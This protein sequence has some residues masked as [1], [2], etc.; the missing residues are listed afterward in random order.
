MTF[1]D[2][3]LQDEA[4]LA[5]VQSISKNIEAYGRD[6]LD[7]TDD[8]N[9]QWGP[10][11]APP[12]L[13][14][15]SGQSLVF[16]VLNINDVALDG[17]NPKGALDTIVR[18]FDI[19]AFARAWREIGTGAPP[20]SLMQTNFL[21]L[22]ILE[23]YGM[24]NQE[25][26]DRVWQVSKIRPRYS[27]TTTWRSAADPNKLI[28]KEFRPYTVRDL[29]PSA[30][31]M[32][33]Y[34]TLTSIELEAIQLDEGVV[35]QWRPQTR[36]LIEVRL[37]SPL[38]L[39]VTSGLVGKSFAEILDHPIAGMIDA[40]VV[41]VDRLRASTRISLETRRPVKMVKLGRDAKDQGQYQKE[42]TRLSKARERLQEYVVQQL[43]PP[44]QKPN[45]SLVDGDVDK[46]GIS[47][48]EHADIE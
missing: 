7:L 10:D 16:P 35:L 15:A 11:G 36:S 37:N 41:K 26:A 27:E 29:P 46:L 5:S 34:S 13:S 38:P 31:W 23:I 22:S 1:K 40:R 20:I 42:R 19:L 9:L 44:T 21:T 8:E 2:N 25:F 6:I 17:R 18:A 14:I 32:A 30:P 4:F 12:C 47:C 3:R 39:T 33:G 48:G 24:A 43:T 28:G 45:L